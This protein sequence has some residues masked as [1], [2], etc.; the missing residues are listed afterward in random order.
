MADQLLTFPVRGIFNGVSQQP[1]HARREGYAEAQENG[2]SSIVDGLRKRPPTEYKTKLAA[3]ASPSSGTAIDG[4]HFIDR[5]GSDQYVVLIEDAEIKVYDLNG[6]AKTVEV[7]DGQT[8]LQ[9]ATSEYK[10]VTLADVTF[11]VN[12]EKTVAMSST[13]SAQNPDP[14]S[15]V[16]G[17]DSPPQGLVFLKGSN[18]SGDYS[19]TVKNA[20]GSV[21][22]TATR[23][24]SGD[25]DA[26]AANLAS[27]INGYSNFT[28]TSDG[29]TIYV[30]SDSAAEFSMTSKHEKGDQFIAVCKDSVQQFSDLPVVAPE[31]FIIKIEGAP[32]SKFDDYYVKFQIDGSP[33]EGT[34][35]EGIW[36]E[37]VAPGVLYT[38]DTDTM[39]H[40][41]VKQANGTFVFMEASGRAAYSSTVDGA[42]STYDYSA[43]KW[44]E[45]TVGADETNEDPFFVGTKIKNVVFHKNRLGF[46][47]NDQMCLSEA[48]EFFN[49]FLVSVQDS[50]ATDRINLEINH[51]DA[52]NF[53]SAVSFQDDLLLF[54]SSDQFRVTG[55]PILSNDTVQATVL[56]SFQTEDTSVPVASSNKVFFGFSRANYS[57]VTE[58]TPSKSVAD[59]YDDIETTLHVPKYIPSSIRRF[60][61]HSTE[62]LLCALSSGETSSL[63]AY[64]YF[65]NQ[66]ETVQSSWS[67]FTFQ[68]ANIRGMA[69]VDNYLYLIDQRADG[70]F[71]HRMNFQAKQV[72]PDSDYVTYLDR[73]LAN[74]TTGVSSSYSSSTG[75]TTFTIPY[76]IGTGATVGVV[77]RSTSSVTGG[78]R[79]NVTQA[80]AGS[81]S[82]VVEGDHTSSPV[83]IGEDYSMVYEFSPPS[84]RDGAG[85]VVVPGRL[86]VRTGTVTYSESGYFRVEVTPFKRDAYSYPYTG[87][88]IGAS[89]L[90]I[91]ANPVN[92]GEF[93]FPVR[94]RGSD[95]VIKIINDTALP[96]NIG[97]IYFEG[98][99]TAR[100][101]LS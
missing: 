30:R 46:L 81:T 57:G 39:P 4:V 95:V 2:Y 94:T 44:A 89:G 43:F 23:T 33:T 76:Q 42:T 75:K 38:F 60:A 6:N 101:K 63:F 65:E 29:P 26:D 8:Y 36:L 83:W 27:T 68:N 82:V 50:L 45:K 69:F 99:Y 79:L 18:G 56:S 67:K 13:K 91:G 88:T 35:G 61:A 28:A 96:S 25:I 80:T 5:G 34:L 24:D 11:I 53:H 74:T 93:R 64:K 97:T 86:Q 90:S 58:L 49:F 66:G 52:V 22:G 21:V 47:T 40:I 98:Q 20:A 84:V 14:D 92:T 10:F 59:Q 17:A 19:V 70:W 31:G 62:S 1:P 55:S 16:G 85:Q 87:R 78:A 73:R 100:A 7:P 32:E 41:L 71:L 3:Y 12:S 77:T 15:A 48:G 37:C 9:G 51:S 72:D 54:G